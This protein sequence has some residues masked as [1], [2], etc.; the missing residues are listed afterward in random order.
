[1]GMLVGCGAADSVSPNN[2]TTNQTPTPAAKFSSTEL[3][4]RTIYTSAANT[5]NIFSYIGAYNFNANGTVTEAINMTTT[6]TSSASKILSGTYSID[7]SGVVI[8]D[9]PLKTTEKLWKTAAAADGY[10]SFTVAS[11][12]SSVTGRWFFDTTLGAS[13]ALAFA[14]GKTIP[15]LTNPIMNPTLTAITVTSGSLSGMVG[16]AQQFTATGIY[17]DMT[18]KI[19][20]SSV[21]WVSSN[22]SVCT[23]A[24][25]GIATVITAGQS[26]ISAISGSV[27]GTATFTGTA[28][29]TTGKNI[30]MIS[31]GL[32]FQ[33]LALAN[34]LTVWVTGANSQG[35]LGDGTTSSKN[36]PIHL[37]TLSNITAVSTGT[38]SSY[39]LD[40]DG[41]VWAWGGNSSGELGT[42]TTTNSLV[43]VK[44]QGITN[45]IAISAGAGCMAALKSDGTVWVWGYNWY[46]ISANG[47]TANVLAPVQV[48]GV[49]NITAIANEGDCIIALKND[50]TVWGWGN[51][52]YGQLGNGKTA[53]Y[54]TPVQATGLTNVI[55][56]AGGFGQTFAL[57]ND[58]T[59]WGYGYNLQGQLGDGTATSR[60][61]AVIISSLTSITKIV[62]GSNHAVALKSD[63][64]VFVWGRNASYGVFGNGTSS[65]SLTPIQVS[66]LT[67][68]TSLTA[69]N[70]YSLAIKTD[71]TVWGWGLNS[72]GQLGDGSNISKLS[73]VLVSTL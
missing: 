46:G 20:T 71:G 63:G 56:I 53:S 12:I 29:S 38:N 10:N 51:G 17:S 40:T 33:T 25:S 2:S 70:D 49:S 11:S 59:V 7:S 62:S 6:S 28:P 36:S 43:P 37:S 50:G 52:V 41:F 61:T 54:Q 23:I 72:S 69:G 58:G 3:V 16:T 64:T 73:P 60:T 67:N 19:L 4:G 34:D 57:K 39:A 35:Q 68:V 27:T 21:T 65:T 24:S 32:G 48:L 44:I 26:T 18:T 13:Q 55:A 66:A 14:T 15:P 9:F 30:T 8:I 31:A 22:T 1:M 5:T 42:G 47:S 45:V